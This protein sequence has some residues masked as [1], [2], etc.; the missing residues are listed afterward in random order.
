MKRNGQLRGSE[1]G[2]EGKKEGVVVRR[3]RSRED[4]KERASS[5]RER[6]KERERDEGQGGKGR[7]G[8]GTD[9]T[10]PGY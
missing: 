8:P 7:Y 9:H 2:K 5:K 4:E 3:L 1:D 10:R 6:E